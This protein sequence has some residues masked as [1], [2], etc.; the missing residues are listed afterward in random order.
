MSATKHPRTD[1]F[2]NPLPDAPAP[3]VDGGLFGN[4]HADTSGVIL[5]PTA[6]PPSGQVMKMTFA[7]RAHARAS[8]PDTSHAAAASID[9]NRIS[10]TQRAILRLFFQWYDSPPGRCGAIDEEW[11]PLYQRASRE[12]PGAYPANTDQSLRSRRANL[13]EKGLMEA[14]AL[15]PGEPEPRTA[16][17]RAASVWRLTDKGREA[18]AA[19]TGKGG[20]GA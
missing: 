18:A 13:V 16:A 2:G 11:V 5:T 4:A 19:L 12:C 20:R 6:P 15:L 1:P 10:D 14:R 17:N 8:D 7:P 3:P 9:P